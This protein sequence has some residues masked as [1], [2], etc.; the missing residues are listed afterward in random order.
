[1]KNLKNA[2]LASCELKKQS[3]KKMDS[4]LYGFLHSEVF[5]N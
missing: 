1:M 4:Y 5:I 2:Y 3:N